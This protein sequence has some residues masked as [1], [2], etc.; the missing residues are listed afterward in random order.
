MKV[1]VNSRYFIRNEEKCS[2]IIYAGNLIRAKTEKG[3]LVSPI[4]PFMGFLLS[5]FNGEEFDT[6]IIKAA[7]C[8]G[9][10]SDKIETFINKVFKNNE[11][12][13]TCFNNHKLYFPQHL[14]VESDRNSKCYTSS[15]ADLFDQFNPVRMSM[16]AYLNI[17][18]TS[19]CHTNCIYCY[20]D[21]SRKDDMQTS[22]ILHIIEEAKKGGI[23]NV[24]PSGGDIF[25]NKDW[26]II[27]KK[28]TE[29]DYEPFLS[30]K[31]PLSED[32]IIYLRQIDIKEIQYS[33]DSFNAEVVHRNLRVAGVDYVQ[34]IKDTIFYCDKH[35]LKIHVKTVLTK[36]NSSVDNMKAMFDLFSQYKNIASWNIAPA[37]CSVYREDY[38]TYKADKNDLAQVYNYF[39]HLC[40]DFRL[41]IDHLVDRLS[42]Y[43]SFRTVEDFV[44][45]NKGCTANT[46][47]MSVF[48]N[49]KVSVCEMLYY[50]DFFYIG[51]V[52]KNSIRDIWGSQ[53]AL[54]F[55]YF[56]ETASSNLESPCYDC[57]VLEKCKKK[58]LKKIC[59]AD[60][61][62]TFGWKKWDY[63][64]PRCPK[65]PECDLE[66]VM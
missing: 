50:N 14:L 9:I 52:N 5:M 1:T 42:D 66:R 8:L 60:I 35:R 38:D 65:A 24:I 41:Y 17:M 6:T 22:T 16:P 64:D 55:Y 20:A 13:V 29:F 15:T 28:L 46:F 36:F 37:F 61:I 54:A 40:P 21:R 53:K 18:I 19:K 31:V 32:D 47:S 33:L 45:K 30:T 43:E 62:N 39:I 48:S 27:L 34:K 57:S 56:K 59:Y 12:Y 23:V 10:S 3:P 26:R 2:F 63:P 7:G 44:E 11:P 49:G 25:A 51:D 4:P 58:Q